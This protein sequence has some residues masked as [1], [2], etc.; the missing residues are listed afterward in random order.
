MADL[1]RV[2]DAAS[3]ARPTMM[4]SRFRTGHETLFPEA[5]FAVEHIAQSPEAGVY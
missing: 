5:P 1:W 3:I 2:P 4:K